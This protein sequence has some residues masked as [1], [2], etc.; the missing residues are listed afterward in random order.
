MLYRAKVVKEKGRDLG[1]VENIMWSDDRSFTLFPTNGRVYI[2]SD[3]I[4]A[5]PSGAPL[6][7]DGRKTQGNLPGLDC[8]SVCRGGAE[9]SSTRR[10]SP[11]VNL[12]QSLRV[13]AW[14]VPSRREDDH[15]SL[16]SSEL[17]HLNI[18]LAALSEAQRPDSGEI[19]A[20]GS[21]HYWSGRSDGLP[22]PR[23][24]CSFVQ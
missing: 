10:R 23:S 1:T 15:P 21:T 19:M 18:S 20:G 14:N 7:D 2:Y 5:K 17:Q 22:R 24:C 9:V 13:S 12:R 3:G 11:R 8:G 4:G 6:F 16:L